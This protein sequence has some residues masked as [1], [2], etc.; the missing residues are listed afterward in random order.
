M[1][2]FYNPFISAGGDETAE[3]DLI[4]RPLQ[5]DRRALEALIVRH[6]SWIYNIALRTVY[7]PCAAED[8]TQEVLIKLITKLGTYNPARAAF[9]TWLYRLV[10][11]H[12]INAKRSRN[13]A[14]MEEAL[15][16]EGFDRFVEGL[17]DRR[18][19]AQP[20][21]E[22]YQ[23]EVKMACVQ[24]LLFSLSR[25]ERVI[26]ILGVVFGIPDA[27]GSEICDVSRSNFRKILS[28]ARSRIHT[29]FR[30]RC[31]LL[32]EKNPCR[33]AYFLSPLVRSGMIDTEDLIVRRDSHGTV[34]DVVPAAVRQIEASYEEFISL[35]R[36]QPFL[37]SPDM[38]R[39]LRDLLDH[40]D[41]KPLFQIA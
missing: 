7:D 8:V 34:A 16:G 41:I 17:P 14:A 37:K 25:R 21:A 26:F 28:R 24:C 39:W 13:E 38:I 40:E 4:S 10:V 27:V 22:L 19:T 1:K 9:R 31:S 12:I 11:N 2:A 36:S 5:G 32:D 20:G 30:D 3:A 18:L 35:F 29:F 33:C 23:E 6:Q 15:R